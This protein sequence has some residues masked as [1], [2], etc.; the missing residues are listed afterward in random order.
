MFGDIWFGL[1][2]NT[3]LRHYLLVARLRHPY[4]VRHLSNGVNL[5]SGLAIPVLSRDVF[6]QLK[7]I[8]RLGGCMEYV[9]SL[10]MKGYMP[11][12]YEH[13]LEEFTQDVGGPLGYMYMSAVMNHES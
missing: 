13:F 9:T 7:F 10:G 1:Y 3:L 6:E 4:R 12:E 8:S 11:G 2:E 5:T